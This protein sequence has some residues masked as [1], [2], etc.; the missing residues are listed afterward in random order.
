[1]GVPAMRSGDHARHSCPVAALPEISEGWF[2]MLISI[3]IPTH[4]RQQYAAAAARKIAVLLPEAQLVVSDTSSDDRLRG[5]LPAEVDYVRPGQPM[6]V[7][8]HFEFALDH[9]RG[10]YVMFLGDDDCIGPGLEA[11]ATWA[12]SNNID[13]VFSY[14]TSFIA[15]YFWPGVRSRF[16]GDGYASRLFVHPFTGAAQRIDPVAALRT[17][18]RDFGRGLG[19]MPRVYHGLVSR[20]LIDKVKRRHGAL[21]GGVTPDIYSATLLSDQAEN[22]WQVD[23]PFCLPGGSPTSTAG[24]GAARSDMTSLAEHPHT[25]AFGDLRW[26]PLIPA[27]Y[28]PYI[29]WA[30]SLKKAVDQLDRPDLAPNLPRIYALSLLRNHE[31]RGR[32]ARSCVAARAAPGRSGWSRVGWEMGRELAFQ[33][34]RYATRVTSPRAGGRAERFGELDDIAAA[35]DRLERYI[36]DNSIALDL[37]ALNPARRADHVG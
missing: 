10:R 6:D 24:T 7:V 1:M 15:N 23:Y 35:Y 30:Y 33:A 25:A 3:V 29:V 19:T 31:Q 14:G 26:D 12:D 2:V 13:A 32:I 21:F 22:V 5:M 8:S 34:R 4:G 27:F 16:Y 36:T 11:I 28:A 20:A 17:T 37:P 18:L 9:A